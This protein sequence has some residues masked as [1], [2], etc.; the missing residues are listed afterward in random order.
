[1]AQA[2]FTRPI[3]LHGARELFLKI[4]YGLIRWG[5]GFEEQVLALA[6]RRQS[7]EEGI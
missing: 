1:V 6:A 7:R 4:K 3:G 2:E 5:A